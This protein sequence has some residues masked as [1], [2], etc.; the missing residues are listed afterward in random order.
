MSNLFSGQLSSSAR[1]ATA[2]LAL[3]LFVNFVACTE[4]VPVRGGVDAS[5]QPAVR[6]TLTDQGTIDVAPR[7]GM[8]AETL[9]GLLRS[10]SDT[11]LALS[12]RKV[13]REGGIEDIYPGETLTLL[14]RDY[15][16]VATARTSVPRSILLAGGIIAGSLLI[17]RGAGDLSGGKTA[18]PPPPTR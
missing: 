3:V 6:V 18:G 2:A 13:S 11:S 15:E 16:S 1:R 7:I 5:A 8:R 12:V 17:A 10:V 14:R 4:Y 9:E